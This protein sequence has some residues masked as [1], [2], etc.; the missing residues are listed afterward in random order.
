MCG[1]A[2]PGRVGAGTLRGIESDGPSKL[3]IPIDTP[4]TRDGIVEIW[5]TVHER[6]RIGSAMWVA[7]RAKGVREGFARRDGCVACTG[8]CVPQLAVLPPEM[9]F[10]DV[11]GAR[12]AEARQLARVMPPQVCITHLDLSR[13][14]DRL[15]S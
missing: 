3:A 13:D 11:V 6:L 7:R 12:R 4:A 14:V 15:T 1:M 2:T 10:Q 5:P 9:L 8:S